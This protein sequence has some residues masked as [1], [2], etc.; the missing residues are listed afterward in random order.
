MIT[1]WIQGLLRRRFGSLAATAA[2]VAIAVAMIASLGSFIASAQSSMTAR[3]ASGVA[4]DWQ[5]QVAPNADPGA[6]ATKTRA[7][8]GVTKALP[9]GFAH[10]T[11]L[12]ATS[13]GTSQ[14]TGPAIILG[15]PTGYAAAFPGE[16][17]FLS[18]THNGVLIAQQTAANLHVMPGD[19]VTIGLEGVTP[20]AVT[21]AGVIDLPQANSLFQTVGAP[22]QSQPLAP[23]DNVL[24]V[25][26]GTYG[27]ISSAL[28]VAHPELVSIQI[29]AA[30]SHALAADPAVSYVDITSAAHNLEATL[31]GSGQ[32]GDN[33]GAA[34]GA[35]RGDSGYATVLFLFLGLPG[36]VLAGLLTVAVATSGRDRRRREQALLRTRGASARLVGRLVAS[37]ALIVGTIGGAV[38][39]AVAALVGAI[40]FGT[41]GF[42]QSPVSATIWPLSAFLIGLGIAVGAVVIPAIRD[43]RTVIVSQARAQLS[44]DHTPWWA[45]IWLDLIL[46]AVSAAVFSITT[47]DGYSLVLAPE[48][49][50]SIQVNYWAFFGPALFWVG[51]GLLI[52]RIYRSVLRRRQG[53]VARLIRPITGSLSHTSSHMMSRTSPVLARG[54]VMFALALTF[55]ISTSVFNSTYQHQ[56]EVDARLTNGA[57]IAITEPPGSHT[58][59]SAGTTIQKVPGVGAVEP[60]QHRYAYVG[61]DLQDLFGVRA[62]SITKATLLQDAYFQGGTAEQLMAKLAAQPDAILVSSE[63]VKDFQLHPGDLIRLRLQNATTQSLVT[64][65]FH[66][67]GVANEFPTAPKDSFFV[68]NATYI[69]SQT[70]DSSVSSFLVDTGGRG[71]DA[72]ANSLRHGLGTSATVTSIGAARSSVGSSLTSV[73]LGGLTRVELTFALLIAAASGGLLFVLG[74]SERKRTFAIATVLGAR[75]RQLRALVLAEAA[76]V[77]IGG[78]IAGVVLGAVLSHMLASVLTGVFDPPPAALTVP[79]SYLIVAG[80]IA[81]VAI[82]A[83]AIWSARTAHRPAIETIREL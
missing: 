55:A 15:L 28:T 75:R 23:P 53:T 65:P 16:I 69:S 37:E 61:S 56:A 66:Y 32:V 1:L 46:L 71:T 18:G 20:I 49:V 10:S 78:T 43:F 7:A 8:S 63:T 74:Q 60:L 83:G 67:V 82:V 12:S 11:G 2:G 29:H 62:S 25:P 27:E 42:G 17:R 68:A 45:R 21:V 3:A 51:A 72:V 14:T 59:V 33:L 19:S 40:S 48:G 38:G 64:V 36:A 13:N 24:L 79:W 80:V 58:P 9:V 50:A 73:D 41:V 44:R 39:L 35:A 52:W 81:I 76:V 5:V 54:A 31:A 47:Q 34:L 30:H 26:S 6:V 4:V 70:G 57:D 77:A 22:A